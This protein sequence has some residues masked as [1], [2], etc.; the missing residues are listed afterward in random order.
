MIFEDQ[1]GEDYQSPIFKDELLQRQRM[2]QGNKK[3]QSEECKNFFQ[4]IGKRLDDEKKGLHP[5]YQKSLFQSPDY[6]DNFV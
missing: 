2:A 5:K 3:Q 6:K 1:I 4:F